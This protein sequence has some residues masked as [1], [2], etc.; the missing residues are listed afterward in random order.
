MTHFLHFLHER[1]P[2]CDNIG[3]SH[4]LQELNLH[5]CLLNLLLVHLRDID[6]FHYVLL[7]ALL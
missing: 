3:I 2:I 5:E 7:L 1:L 6:Y 4:D